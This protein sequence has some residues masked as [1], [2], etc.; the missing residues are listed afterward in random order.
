MCKHDPPGGTLADCIEAFSVIKLS[1]LGCQREQG[2]ELGEHTAKE[3]LS[4]TLLG[5][6]AALLR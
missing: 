1:G 2:S 6:K 3:E 4:A 5:H